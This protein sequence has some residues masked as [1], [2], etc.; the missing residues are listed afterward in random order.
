MKQLNTFLSLLKEKYNQQGQWGRI[1]FPTAFLLAVCCLCAIPVRLFSQALGGAPT[2]TLGGVIPTS[3]GTQPTPTALF[4]FDATIFPSPVAP[5]PLPTTPAPATATLTSAPA[6]P[7]QTAVP[8]DTNT[9]P[10]P[11]ASS[12][13]SVRVIAVNKP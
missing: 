1:L 10:P 12:T 4:N 5:S 3:A 9:S 13:G 11:T 8:S 7:T 6:I 2:S